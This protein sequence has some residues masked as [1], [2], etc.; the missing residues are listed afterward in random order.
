MKNIKKFAIN[1]AVMTACAILM[2]TVG[3]GFNV[4]VVNS[5][6]SEAIGLHSLF[7]GVYGFAVTLA[8]F[9]LHLS[10]TRLVSE[11]LA[12]NDYE[13][14]SK[15]IKKCFLFAAFMGSFAFV[16]LSL[17]SRS[18]S[19]TWL[20]DI[21]AL[22]PLRILAVC[23]PMASISS[24][25]NGYFSA[26][27]RVFKNAVS[28]VI[29]MITK[30]AATVAFFS[31]AFTKDA[32]TACVF[33]ACGSLISEATVFIINIIV[34][35]F[36]RSAHLPS[37]PVG[38]PRKALSDKVLSK[39]IL[40]ISL[41][42][43]LTSCVRSALLAIEHSLIPIGLKKFGASSSSSLS[44]YGTLSGMALPVINFPYAIIGSFSSLLIPEI[45]ESRAKREIRHLKYIVHRSL[46]ATSIF[47]ICISGMFFMFSDSL[48]TVLYGSGEAAE[49]IR[50]LSF[51]TP[52][53]YSD[54]VTDAIL[55]GM[56]EQLYTMKVNIADALISVALVYFLVPIYGIYGYIATIYIAEIINTALSL[57]KMLLVTK[58]K[59]SIIKFLVCPVFAVLGS[60]CV[61]NIVLRLFA[62]SITLLILGVILYV[63]VYLLL[64]FCMGG[65]SKEDIRWLK[66]I[67][68]RD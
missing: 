26:V 10:V 34:Y 39:K 33:L 55:K 23:L 50:L 24:V 54:S 17:L 38:P 13:S 47:A 49:Y 66:K 60:V 1:G 2:R 61:C 21:R 35:S 18:L 45:S 8:L 58:S 4:Y 59:I 40:N 65:V 19:V 7:S 64:L 22:R 41:P 63:L 56:G 57:R 37:A 31:F 28:Q 16:A 3:V 51:L 62:G 36:D 25:I 68:L 52:I 67:F 46:H 43:A 12:L 15:T 30:I 29:E 32:E 44:T 27:R 48:G 11:A 42:I 9:G 14:A 53:M 5:V 6:G 20:D